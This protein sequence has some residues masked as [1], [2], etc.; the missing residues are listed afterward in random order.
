M[1]RLTVFLYAAAAIAQSVDLQYDAASPQ[2]SFAATE[3]RRAFAAHGQSLIENGGGAQPLQL[4]IAASPAKSNA[5]A[6]SL[7]V[8]RLKDTGPQCYAIRRAAKGSVTTIAV[9][10]ADAAGA[11]YGGLDLAEAVRLGTLPALTPPITRPTSRSAASSSTSRSTRAPPAIPITAT[12]PKTTS[13][14]CGAWI[15]GT[16]SSTRWRATATT[17]CRSGACTRSLR[18]SKCPSSPTWH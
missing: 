16:R 3:I 18:S 7:G 8:A 6:D 14:K 17:C 12:P 4:V 13:P 2:V 11:M 1:M 10:A 5:L 9:L 15:S